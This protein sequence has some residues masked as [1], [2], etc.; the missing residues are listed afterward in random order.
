MPRMHALFSNSS[1]VI[2]VC[3]YDNYDVA[4]DDS[5]RGHDKVISIRKPVDRE[6]R[7]T[8]LVFAAG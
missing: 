8:G 6:T 3:N 2:S 7:S 5:N 1:Q 4:L